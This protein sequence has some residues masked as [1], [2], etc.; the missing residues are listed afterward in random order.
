MFV[1]WREILESD[2]LQTHG[3]IE[4]NSNDFYIIR[5][6]LYFL[7]GA[8]QIEI[9][10]NLDITKKNNEFFCLVDCCEESGRLI[11]SEEKVKIASLSDFNIAAFIN[12]F[13]TKNRT[14]ISSEI[15]KIQ[16]S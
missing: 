10:I 8:D 3:K 14:E 1:Y 9:S 7:A 13:F 12:Q 11:G 2:H 16:S 15:R 5:S 6:K 4:H